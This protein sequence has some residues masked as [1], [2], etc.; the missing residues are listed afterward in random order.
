MDL[1]DETANMSTNGCAACTYI[2]FYMPFA[3]PRPQTI[4]HLDSWTISNL[5]YH[6][7]ANSRGDQP[8]SAALVQIV[9]SE[10]L[11]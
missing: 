10:S 7:G 1:A 2:L 6:M 9:Q 3:S 8:G 11:D 5:T 4:A